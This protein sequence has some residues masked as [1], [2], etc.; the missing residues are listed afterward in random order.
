MNKF[1]KI[2]AYIVIVL[3]CLLF[4]AA[5]I[6]NIHDGGWVRVLSWVI[7]GAILFVFIWAI[8]EVS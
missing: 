1:K 4:I 3:F 8:N 6:W 7:T 5:I 2:V